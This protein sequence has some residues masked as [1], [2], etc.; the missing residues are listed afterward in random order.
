MTPGTIDLLQ[1]TSPILELMGFFLAY[2]EIRNKALAD[3][4]ETIIDKTNLL[5]INLL[6]EFIST[7][8]ESPS[9]FFFMG[10][11]PI[12]ACVVFIY[13]TD[14]EK[15]LLANI[16]FIGVFVFLTLVF[17][18]LPIILTP[19][20]TFLN[21]YSNGR[22]LGTFGL[23]LALIGICME[24]IQLADLCYKNGCYGFH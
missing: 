19:F 9:N 12:V 11:F 15:E 13:F 14:F 17:I 18:A 22:A 10:I 21:H 24:G 3:R 20:L 1:Q 16:I 8:S 7:I 2:I 6:G 23:L 4:I 5:M